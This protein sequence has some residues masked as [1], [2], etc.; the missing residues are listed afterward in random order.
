MRHR[1]TA[2]GLLASVAAW[3]LWLPSLAQAQVDLTG[4]WVSA[5]NEGVYE[6]GYGPDLGSYMGVPLTAEGRAAALTYIGDKDEQLH[7]Q[8][9]PWL[10]SYLVVSGFGFPI[11]ATSDPVSGKVLA[12]H[13]GGNGIDRLPITIWIDGRAPAPPQALHTYSGYTT[14]KW[15]GN[16]LVATT[17]HIKDGLLDRNGLPT[18]NQQTIKFFIERDEDL[19]TITALVKDP[20]YLEA[21]LPLE[22]S[23]Q[24][25]TGGGGGAG[26]NAGLA[27]M[28]CIPS[29]TIAGL[30]DGYH[31]ISESPW[32]SAA[33]TNMTKTYGIP[34]DAAMGGVQTMY[35]EF[36]KRVAAEYKPPAAYCKYGCCNS[37]VL[38]NVD[39][40]CKSAN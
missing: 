28:K 17:T 34:E 32:T 20:V 3:A 33:R 14:G 6:A 9:A 5:T 21:P 36:R 15:E 25:A 26:A 11:W 8:C 29:E 27:P 23:W 35:P 10:I 39:T 40:V 24:L 18:S 37:S 4:R 16:T 12:W 2:S 38:G 30:S 7:R 22:S 13:I 1:F 31:W 19:L